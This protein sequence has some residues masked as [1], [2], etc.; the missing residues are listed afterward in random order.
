MGEAGAD[1]VPPLTPMGNL[2][3]VR[4]TE[5][6][7]VDADTHVEVDGELPGIHAAVAVMEEV[8]SH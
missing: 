6:G 5:D 2:C 4:R 8:D 1:A 3:S 7:G